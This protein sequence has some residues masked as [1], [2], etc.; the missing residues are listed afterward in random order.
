MIIANPLQAPTA[1]RSRARDAPPG[2]RLSPTRRVAGRVGKLALAAGIVGI[3]GSLAWP[4]LETDAATAKKSRG[5][6]TLEGKGSPKPAPAATEEEAVFRLLI[7]AV[8]TNPASGA[9]QLLAGR[10][11]RPLTPAQVLELVARDNLTLA[12][13]HHLI[14]SARHGVTEAESA[15]DPL[16]DMGFN[17]QLTQSYDRQELITRY[18][19]V[20][21][22]QWSTVYL[23]EEGNPVEDPATIERYRQE[24]EED[25]LRNRP[26]RHYSQ[27]SPYYMTDCVRD[28]VTLSPVNLAECRRNLEMK[29][30]SEGSLRGRY[31][32]NW[33]DKVWSGSFGV[34][35]VFDWGFYLS[36]TLNS[37]LVPREGPYGA[38]FKSA[39][40][41]AR[42][43]AVNLGEKEWTSTATASL[44]TPLPFTKNFGPDGNASSVQV[45]LAK[46]NQERTT[47]DRETRAN[48]LARTALNTY[49]ELVRAAMQLRAAVEHQQVRTRRVQKV[50]NLLEAGKSTS[51]NLIQAQTLV[52]N[53]RT[54][55]ELAWNDLL[56]RAN[57]LAELLNLPPRELPV[58]KDYLGLLQAEEGAVPKRDAVLELALRGRP[59]IKA[60]RVAVTSQEVMLEFRRNQLAP[61]VSFGANYTIG[62]SNKVLAYGSFEESL[63]GLADPDSRSYYLGLKYSYPLDNRQANSAH[64]QAITRRDQALDRQRRAEMQVVEEVNIAVATG[65]STLSQIRLTRTALQLANQAYEM[66]VSQLEMETP[67]AT[68]FEVLQRQQERQDARYAHI[69]ALIAHRQARVNLLGAQGELGRLATAG[70]GKAAP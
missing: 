7:A 31:T 52:E 61:E 55:E 39:Q 46:L 41:N 18:W 32:P 9:R 35:K 22:D 67:N 66:A 30:T 33:W 40:L 23:D 1:T 63:A 3:M 45:R 26:R 60:S 65:S 2:P 21:K 5:T 24:N 13:H 37:T 56:V 57:Q 38:N 48:L 6:S 17:Y 44:N 25:D 15:F 43:T 58:P 36:A 28:P 19:T 20:P 59:E 4:V 34:S 68:E 54:Q 8:Q 49:W 69:D 42:D 10:Q 12:Q 16:L 64:A 29:T 11:L 14:E 53:A 50:Q 27:D 62:E 51:Y 70:E 47:L